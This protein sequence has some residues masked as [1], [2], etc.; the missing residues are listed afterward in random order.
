MSTSKRPRSSGSG[1]DQYQAGSATAPSTAPHSEIASIES[2]KPSTPQMPVQAK[3]FHVAG[4]FAA[5]RRRA[6]QPLPAGARR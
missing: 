1:S 4:S 3:S 5:T 2:E 6:N